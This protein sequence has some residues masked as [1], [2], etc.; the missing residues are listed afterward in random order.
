MLRFNIVFLESI[1]KNK[2]R[3]LTLTGFEQLVVAKMY[4]KLIHRNK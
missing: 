4:S 3:G 1:L 2:K